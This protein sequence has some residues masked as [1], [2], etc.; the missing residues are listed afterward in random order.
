MTKR[1]TRIFRRAERLRD[2][3]ANALV[4]LAICLPLMLTLVFGLIDFSRMILDKQIMAGISRQGSDLASRTYDGN[5]ASL[6]NVVS[7]LVTQGTALNIGTNGRIIVTVVADDSNNGGNP[8]IEDQA[9]SPSPPGI[10]ATSQVGILSTT[11]KKNSATMPADATLVLSAGRSF[12]VTEVF[13]SY[14]PITPVGSFLKK[15]LAS[16]FYE[17]AYF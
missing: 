17:V 16:T 6:Q 5:T 3:R 12:Y 2:E 13:Y 7:S 11:T 10:A 8:T 4:E 1:L 14:S 15:S 9:E